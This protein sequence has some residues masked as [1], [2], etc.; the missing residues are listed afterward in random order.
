[1]PLHAVLITLLTVFLLGIAMSV[2]SRA[3]GQHRGRHDQSSAGPHGGVVP[4]QFAIAMRDGKTCG[5]TLSKC[6]LEQLTVT[7]FA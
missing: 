3:R 1:M 5:I 6:H 2:V 4:H 7:S